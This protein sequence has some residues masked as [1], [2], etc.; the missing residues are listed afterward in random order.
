[1]NQKIVVTA[2]IIM[3]LLIAVIGLVMFGGTALA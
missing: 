2:V 3:L 1:M